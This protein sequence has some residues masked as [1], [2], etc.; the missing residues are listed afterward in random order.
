MTVAMTDGKLSRV[1]NAPKTP[2]KCFRIPEDL[3][4]E[5]MQA[6]EANGETLT[7]AVRSFMVR[8]VK[9]TARKRAAE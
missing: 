4:R 3:Y 7:D 2:M 8:Y 6:A 9:A 5:A 1:P